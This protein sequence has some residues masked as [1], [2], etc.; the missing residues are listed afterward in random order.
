MGGIEQ[1]PTD[2]ATLLHIKLK[3][4]AQERA[5]RTSPPSTT[6]PYRSRHVSG[7]SS[8]SSGSYGYDGQAIYPTSPEQGNTIQGHN[9]TSSL[10][11]PAQGSG[12]NV[13]GS[14]ANAGWY[15]TTGVLP[16]AIPPSAPDDLSRSGS[17]GQRSQLSKYG[18]L[19]DATGL[20]RSGTAKSNATGAESMHPAAP[21]QQKDLPK[22]PVSPE[23]VQSISGLRSQLLDD[24]AEAT[25]IN[26]SAGNQPHA[27]N[28]SAIPTPMRETGVKSHHG[29]NDQPA[30]PTVVTNAAQTAQHRRSVSKERI[31]ASPPS[32]SQGVLYAVQPT[33]PQDT[34]L[35]PTGASAVGTGALP[36][37]ASSGPAQMQGRFMENMDI[38][39]RQSEDTHRNQELGMLNSTLASTGPSRGDSLKNKNRGADAALNHQPSQQLQTPSSQ[40]LSSHERGDMLPASQIRDARERMTGDRDGTSATLPERMGD[41]LPASEIAKQR[42]LRNAYATEGARE[43]PRL[44]AHIIGISDPPASAPSHES[45][46]RPPPIKQETTRTATHGPS[47]QSTRISEPK[48]VSSKTQRYLEHPLPNISFPSPDH[49]HI[50]D[51]FPNIAQSIPHYMF[52]NYTASICQECVAS[53]QKMWALTHGGKKWRYTYSD[54]EEEKEMKS[55]DPDT[56]KTGRES[57]T[58]TISILGSS[59]YNKDGVEQCKCDECLKNREIVR[60]AAENGLIEKIFEGRRHPASEL[61]ETITTT[62]IVRAPIIQETVTTIWCEEP[63]CMECALKQK[64][65]EEAQRLEVLNKAMNGM[66]IHETEGSDHYTGYKNLLDV[67]GAY[68]NRNDTA[69]AA[70]AG[71]ETTTTST[72]LGGKQGI[73]RLLKVAGN[74]RQE[75]L[76]RKQGTTSEFDGH[77]VGYDDEQL[78]GRSL[79][80]VQ[81]SQEDFRDFVMSGAESRS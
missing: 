11:A 66:V 45:A 43:E 81:P 63:N 16:A 32:Q 48:V 18:S 73:E 79:E 70:A 80:D 51:L 77:I 62:T 46:S 40:G 42:D 68:G 1:S 3:Q 54:P 15:M 76:R 33:S 35:N 8:G 25:A 65:Y 22:M 49:P 23:Y 38:V 6:S 28:V 72:V 74:P 56:R 19:Y 17:L 14:G 57:F 59:S 7:P 26:K 41:A 44:A 31:P 78:I 61:I 21:G 50:Q 67:N 58:D 55:D 9:R 71:S 27:M 64:E 34:P 12:A 39:G 4:E 5:M 2:D 37:A 29:S 75:E 13:T 53:E 52:V 24:S 36:P 47:Y 10:A 69:N 30:L 20:D 60:Y